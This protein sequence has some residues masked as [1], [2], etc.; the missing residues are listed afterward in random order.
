ML[1]NTLK[2]DLPNA[3]GCPIALVDNLKIELP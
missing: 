2:H 3:M 1:V